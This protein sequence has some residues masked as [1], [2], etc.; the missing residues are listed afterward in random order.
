MRLNPDQDNCTGPCGDDDDVDRPKYEKNGGGRLRSGVIKVREQEDCGKHNRLENVRRKDRNRFVRKSDKQ[1]VCGAGDDRNS[2]Q[3]LSRKVSRV[4]ERS[5]W[6]YGFGAKIE[7]ASA[8]YAVRCLNAEQQCLEH[9]EQA[10]GGEGACDED[11]LFET[12]CTVKIPLGRNSAPALDVAT[13]HGGSEESQVIEFE[14]EFLLRI[15]FWHK[16]RHIIK[17]RKRLRLD[18]FSRGHSFEH[19]VR[20]VQVVV[21]DHQIVCAG[22]LCVRNFGQCRR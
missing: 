12:R 15:Y 19:L 8:R 10:N 2:E 4:H 16:L 3:R 14:F 13:L 11:A 21:D 7:G 9:G 22:L 1:E 20:P 17:C 18:F 6:P 5:E